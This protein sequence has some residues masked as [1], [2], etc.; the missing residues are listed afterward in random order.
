MGLRASIDTGA[1]QS[2]R[3]APVAWLVVAVI[4][5]FNAVNGLLD[6][7]AMWHHVLEVVLLLIAASFA[8]YAVAVIRRRRAIDRE[9]SD[10]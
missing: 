3:W 2:K 8:A 5:T 1:R 6:Q 10:E 7:A 4:W 9:T